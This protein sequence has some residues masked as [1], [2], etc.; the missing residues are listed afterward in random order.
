MRVK[1]SWRCREAGCRRHRAPKQ[2]KCRVHLGTPRVRVV[3]KR[4]KRR[5][6]GFDHA[7]NRRSAHR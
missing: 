6:P 7:A 4:P 2:E 3:P 5:W 1:K